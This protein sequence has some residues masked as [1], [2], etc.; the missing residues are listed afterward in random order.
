[1]TS[2]LLAV[3]LVAP[4]AACLC[5]PASAQAL[6]RLTVTSFAL[7]ADTA[8]PTTG[9]PFHVFV[10]LHVRENVPSIQEIELP[11]LAALE[12]LGDER[13][14]ASSPGGTSYRETISL[15]AHAPG[16]IHI[17]PATLDAIDARDGKPK[18]Y[19]TNDLT[20][21]I[22]GASET[23]PAPATGP[24]ALQDFDGA[25][26]SLM[27]WI[28]G[29]VVPTVTAL[30]LVAWLVTRPRAAPPPPHVVAVSEPTPAPAPRDVLGDARAAFDAAPSRATAARVRD[31]ARHVAGAAEKDTLADLDWRVSPTQPR[32]AE[33]LTAAERATFTYDADLAVALDSLRIALERYTA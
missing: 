32:L 21:E 20:L 31:A 30:V 3:A 26:V 29:I 27:I 18:R 17:A 33:L 10:T 9:V 1:M 15:V 23:S 24:S 12:V 6:Q 28:F 16:T 2:R 4:A 8:K 22:T 14:V 19:S 11:S 13:K 25:V 5:A 7:S